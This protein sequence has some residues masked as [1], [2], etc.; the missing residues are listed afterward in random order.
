M[1]EDPKQ[2]EDYSEWEGFD[3]ISEA[4][5]LKTALIPK[6]AESSKTRKT[7]GKSKDKAED[8]SVPSI[9]FDLLEDSESKDA[10]GM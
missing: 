7:K 8:K 1:V 6:P 4:E 5:S 10:D 9:P 3:E 2:N